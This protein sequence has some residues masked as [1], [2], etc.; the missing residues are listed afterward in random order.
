MFDRIFK[1]FGLTKQ[2]KDFVLTPASEV[3][4][5]VVYRRVA[6]RAAELLTEILGQPV[7]LAMYKSANNGVWL[8][9]VP[10]DTLIPFD[11][12]EV[13]NWGTVVIYDS[14]QPKLALNYLKGGK[15]FNKTRIKLHSRQMKFFHDAD[16]LEDGYY[17]YI[18]CM[19][20][21]K[22][23]TQKNNVFQLAL[24]V[25]D[26][27]TLIPGLE[28]RNQIYELVSLIGAAVDAHPSEI[29]IAP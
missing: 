14:T 3:V 20:M 2:D 25:G 10:A 6:I 13:K 9:V 11:L 5:Q 21:F 24:S 26:G 29:E 18:F 16:W 22:C 12:S 15:I 23:A 1:V 4:C 28:C 8:K 27:I 19:H 17:E 7:K